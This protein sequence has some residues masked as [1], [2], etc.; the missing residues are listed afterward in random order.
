MARKYSNEATE[1]LDEPEETLINPLREKV[2][3]VRHIEKKSKMFDNPN[4]VFNGG[5]AETSKRYFVVPQLSNGNYKNVLTNNE[6]A[7]LENVLGLEANAMSV[8]RKSNNFWSS[9]NPMA[10]VELTKYDRKLFLSDPADYI[11]YKILLANSEKICPDSETLEKHYKESYEFVL[12]NDEDE[13]DDKKR[14]MSNLMD[15]YRHYGKIEEDADKLRCI[16]ELINQKPLATNTKLSWLQTTCNDLIQSQTKLFLKTI[17]DPLLDTKVF[18][19]KCIAEGIISNRGGNLYIRK[20]NQP[21][22]AGGEEPTLPVAARWINEP[23]HQDL[24]LTM[25]AQLNKGKE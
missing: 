18:L 22:C 7:Y 5:M 16:I 9:S 2:V 20:D 14:K 12:I 8:H 4:H 17:T 19:K 3:I 10:V 25:E 15:C 21:M 13:M 23:Q 11:Q 1:V 6:K 24:K